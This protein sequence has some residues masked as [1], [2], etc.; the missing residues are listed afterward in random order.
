[1]TSFQQSPVT[2]PPPVSAEPAAARTPRAWHTYW[3]PVD[4][5]KSARSAVKQGIFAALFCALVTAGMAVWAHYGGTAAQK[6][7]V[8]LWALLDAGFFAIVAMG[9]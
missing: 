6:M 1:L 8:N 7:G 2:I 5:L 4:D 9:L 3:P